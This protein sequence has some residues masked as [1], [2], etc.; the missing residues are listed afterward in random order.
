MPA[1]KLTK[2]TMS[3]ALNAIVAAGLTPA[4]VNVE[5]DGSFRIEIHSVEVCLPA[6]SGATDVDQPEKFEDLT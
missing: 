4:N 5:P 2:A 3:N 1:A 6:P